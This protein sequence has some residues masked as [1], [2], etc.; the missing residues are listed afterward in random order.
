MEDRERVV[1]S[2]LLPKLV[3]YSTPQDYRSLGHTEYTILRAYR[4]RFRC[5]LLDQD[6]SLKSSLIFQN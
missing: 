4:E 5:S 1:E 2:P 3:N 6:W